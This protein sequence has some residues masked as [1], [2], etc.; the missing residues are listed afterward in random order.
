MGDARG[1]G[2]FGLTA[3]AAPKNGIAGRD[4][5]AL[6]ADERPSEHLT[7]DLMKQRLLL[8]SDGV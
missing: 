2:E 3:S 1:A 8:P 5:E 7:P 4:F 6:K